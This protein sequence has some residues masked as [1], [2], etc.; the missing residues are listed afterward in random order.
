MQA[1]HNDADE[2]AL[3]KL[4]QEE[5]C[6]DHADYGAGGDSDSEEEG[7]EADLDPAA[8]VG[9]PPCVNINMFCIISAIC[10]GVEILQTRE[11]MKRFWHWQRRYKGQDF[12]HTVFTYHQIMIP[13]NNFNLPCTTRP[14]SLPQWYV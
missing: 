12:Y 5:E 1:K 14:I 13:V 6:D 11:W 8:Q 2:A 7:D 9:F 10:Y 4:L 3:A